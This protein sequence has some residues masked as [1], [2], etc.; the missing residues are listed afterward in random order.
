MTLDQADDF[1][2]EYKRFIVLQGLA[3]TH[4]YPSEGIEKVWCIHMVHSK[5]YI[6]FCNSV[7]RRVFY[8]KPF[9]GDTTGH[10]D[11]NRYNL[12]LQF[13]EQ[14]YL[15]QPPTLIWPPA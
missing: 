9:T 4:L 1:I 11:Q 3:N 15:I 8:H 7:T 12:T 2:H 6:E 13:Y 5:N 14:V 10:E